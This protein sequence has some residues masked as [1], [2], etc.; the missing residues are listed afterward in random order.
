MV[1]R[2]GKTKKKGEGEK[3]LGDGGGWLGMG[4]G[5]KVTWRQLGKGIGRRGGKTL[6]VGLGVSF[7]GIQNGF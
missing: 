6:L 1:P 5:R 4:M 3:S 2:G 7:D